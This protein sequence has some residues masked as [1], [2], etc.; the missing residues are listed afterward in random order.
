MRISTLDRSLIFEHGVDRMAGETTALSST[1]ERPNRLS[2]MVGKI[3]ASMTDCA[4]VRRQRPEQ[5]PKEL[6]D[7]HS[8]IVIPTPARE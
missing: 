7:T 6:P 4:V 3:V 5:P 8:L 2:D 1:S